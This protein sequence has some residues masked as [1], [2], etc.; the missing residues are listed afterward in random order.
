MYKY[1]IR[2]L[3]LVM[4]PTPPHKII[5]SC[6][7]FTRKLTSGTCSYFCTR[8]FDHFAVLPTAEI[9]INYLNVIYPCSYPFTKLSTLVPYP[10]QRASLWLVDETN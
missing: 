5:I 7:I 10:A 8:P 2:K 6:D 3:S 4:P 1:L 9:D